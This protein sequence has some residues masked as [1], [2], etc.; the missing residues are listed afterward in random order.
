MPPAG[1][2]PVGG[3][4]EG[5]KLN[6]VDERTGETQV[7]DC[8][9]WP[10]APT[11]RRELAVAL[12]AASGPSGSLRAL[13]SVERVYRAVRRCA[14]RLVSM[15][16]SPGSVAE[17]TPVMV[18]QL[19]LAGPRDYEALRVLL[20]KHPRLSPATAAA[21]IVAAAP[22]G[23]TP[24]ESFSDAD[25]RR[26]MTHARAD[27][28]RA[29]DRIASNYDLVDK[30][31]AGELEPDSDTW[32]YARHLDVVERTGDVP[33]YASNGRW[34]RIT[35]NVRGISDFLCA[36]DLTADE[37][38]SAGILLAG[39]TG[40]NES[41][42]SGLTVEHQRAD[43]YLPD[44]TS[45]AIA[46]V[47]KGRRGWRRRFMTTPLTN[48]PDWVMKTAQES[49]DGLNTAFGVYTVVAGL[50]ERARQAS[51][52][53]RLLIAR[54]VTGGNGTGRHWVIG[55]SEKGITPRW[56]RAADLDLPLTLSWRR[57]RSTY[58][59][60]HQRGV[61]HTDTVLL[62]AYL[63]NDPQAYTTYRRLVAEVL[64]EQ[65]QEAVAHGVAHMLTDADIVAF[66]E[67][68]EATAARFGLSVDRLGA[69]VDGRRDTALTACGDELD[70]PFTAKG[71]VCTASFLL[72]LGC[73]NAFA[74]PANR[75][76]QVVAH[77]M[78]DELRSSMAPHEWVQRFGLAFAQLDSMLAGLDPLQMDRA[79]E[80]ATDAIRS[81]VT[82]LLGRQLEAS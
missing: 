33:R 6:A 41:G 38:V 75:P 31:R 4:L 50:T 71:V 70:S 23:Q 10:L 5:W 17:I 25:F 49:G 78:L 47:E 53:N 29:R 64:D 52:S 45:V 82:R 55:L 46:D 27:I 72:C 44:V 32:R 79:R 68:P 76:A 8:E 12:A 36:F 80:D 1:W 16:E 9:Q 74:L 7:F 51:G 61:A 48:V 3:S 2:R 15:G 42:I 58:E 30:F 21:M 24:S 18:K 28:R 37:L 67:H 40:H 22:Q 26:V 63:L 57:L 77:D 11:L 81:M 66:E 39:L 59:R 56:L 19:R 62:N 20:R 69:I 14:Q 65:V 54:A 34:L 73:R 60:L 35:G 43:G 13:G